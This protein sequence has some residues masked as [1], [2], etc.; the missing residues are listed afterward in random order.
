MLILLGPSWVALGSSHP[1]SQCLLH[2]G[3][4]GQDLGSLL[5]SHK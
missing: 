5:R 2:R 1:L 4:G 3:G